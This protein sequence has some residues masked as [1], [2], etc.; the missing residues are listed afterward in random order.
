MWCCMM[1]WPDSLVGLGS[2]KRKQI[3]GIVGQSGGWYWLEV[4]AF[5][6]LH[7]V[8]HGNIDWNTQ[9]RIKLGYWFSRLTIIIIL[10]LDLKLD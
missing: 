1:Y 7:I 3:L 9:D 6:M 5:L 2:K 10:I 8:T 4:G